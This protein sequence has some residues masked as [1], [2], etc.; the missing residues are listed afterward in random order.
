MFLLSFLFFVHSFVLSHYI[1]FVWVES[2]SSTKQEKSYYDYEQRDPVTCPSQLHLFTVKYKEVKKLISFLCFFIIL[3]KDPFFFND[4]RIADCG[5]L[6]DLATSHYWKRIILW[7]TV[8]DCQCL[9][10]VSFPF[11]LSVNYTIE[12]K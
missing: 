12:R 11:I 2:I 8:H 10:D 9:G 4:S 3:R 1:L 7:G 6:A 5:D